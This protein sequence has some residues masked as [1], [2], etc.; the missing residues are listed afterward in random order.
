LYESL[1]FEKAIELSRQLL[2]TPRKFTKDDLLL[3]HQFTAYAFFNL[4]KPDSARKHF[5]TILDMDPNYQLDPVT[6]SPKIIRY[7][8]DL[9]TA[10]KSRAVETTI[11]YTRYIF[12][13]DPRPGAAWRSAI[14]PGWGQ[15]YKGQREKALW[16]GTA[17]GVS[18]AFTLVAALLEKHYHQ[19][20]LDSN[21]PSTIS[22]RYNTYNFWY[23]T[24]KVSLALVGTVWL[25]SFADALWAPYAPP[26][27]APSSP[28]PRI[29]IKW[30]EN[31]PVF[32]L[33]LPF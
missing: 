26:A 14:L 17:F 7:F 33:N 23:K 30:Q 31:T 5:V 6:T 3:I 13:K 11:A 24:R 18:T 9:K 1:Q 21:Q 27:T 16:I 29:G 25:A 19:K 2:R 12:I 20:Y 22:D 15:W 8:N 10:L 28:R 4:G 32:V